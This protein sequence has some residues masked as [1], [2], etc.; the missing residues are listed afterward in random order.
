M[1]QTRK[2][3]KYVAEGGNI[4]HYHHTLYRNFYIKKDSE[5]YRTKVD[6][7]YN[8]LENKYVPIF[9]FCP[10]DEDTINVDIIDKMSDLAIM[11]ELDNIIAT[12]NFYN[13]VSRY[14]VYNNNNYENDLLVFNAIRFVTRL[15]N[16]Y[17][18]KADNTVNILDKFKASEEVL[19]AVLKYKRFITGCV[20]F[21]VSF[22]KTLLLKMLELASTGG[23]I[24]SFIL[25]DVFYPDLMDDNCYMYVKTDGP[26][27]T[28]G[29]SICMLEN[30]SVFRHSYDKFRRIYV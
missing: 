16:R 7:F 11:Y 5:I 15:I 2:M 21:R 1:V 10:K 12:P 24:I 30:L 22:I 23:L 8:D 26:T 28:T 27:Y 3:A 14:R 20:D 9:K 13:Y 25:F 29:N 19:V 17:L 18:T 6:R 4:K